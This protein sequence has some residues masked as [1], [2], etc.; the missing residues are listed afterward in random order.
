MASPRPPVSGCRRAQL[1]TLGLGLA[2]LASA[3]P[4]QTWTRLANDAPDAINLML[5]LPDGTVIAAHNYDIDSTIAYSDWYRL[6]PDPSGSYINGT[7]TTIAPMLNTRLYYP[8]QVLRDGRVFVA[9]G[10]YGTGGPYAEIYDPPANAWSDI[11]PPASLWSTANNSFYDCNSELL[12]DGSVLTQP[13]FPHTSGVGLIYHPATNTWTNAGHLFRGSY[14]DEASW[15][16]LPDNSILTIDPFG[17]NS[18]RYIPATNTWVNDSVVPTTMYDPY[19]DELGG[20]T[21]LPNG[22]AFFLGAT[23]HTAIYTPSGT[24]SPGTWIAGPTIPGAH[25]TPDA[26]AAMMPNGRL[27][28]SVSP[29]PTSANH[30]PPPTTFYEYDWQSNSFTSVPATSGPSDPLSCY[31]GAMLVLPDGGVLFSHFATDVYVYQSSGPPLAI[32]KPVVQ[33]VSQNLD[34]TYHLTGT[35]LNGTCVGAVYGDD[36]QMNTNFP[37]VRLSSGNGNIYCA[38]TFNWSTTAVRTGSQVVTTEFALPTNLPPATYSLV[39]VANG[40]ASDPVCLSSPTIADQPQSRAACVGSPAPFSTAAAGVVPF[41]YQWQV[42][43][44]PPP[45]QQWQTVG[46]DPMPLTCGGSISATPFNAAATTIT[47]QGCP[48]P[49][50]VRALISNLCG[51]TATDAATLTINSADFNGDGSVGTDADI[52]AFFACL[53]GDCCP[54]CGSADF[55]GDGAVGTDADIESFFRVLAG[56]SC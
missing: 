36:L 35:G 49:F 54:T 25:G 12:P 3:A 20:A 30:F 47:A 38:R 15:V 16:K 18:E 27:L 34:G 22:N 6:T 11:T 4:A 40:V 50:H 31:T 42:E 13:V 33:S 39:V 24:T 1:L 28:C 53:S 21:L 41:T 17:T 45:N 19:G 44:A 56:G 43:T 14:Q 55:N 2:V 52:E 9:G 46:A 10:E 32:A 23:G 29:V 37:L 8:A 5:Q 51:T 26:P 48:G 7:W